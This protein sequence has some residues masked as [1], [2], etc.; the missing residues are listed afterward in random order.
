M[1]T[2]S[3]HE[4]LVC[5]RYVRMHDTLKC[6]TECGW[7]GDSVDESCFVEDMPLRAWGAVLA[8]VHSQW[9]QQ[10]ITNSEYLDL[11]SRYRLMPGKNV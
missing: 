5:G 7:L 11:M 9:R 2:L 3:T 8:L 4:C 1:S 6:C 10:I